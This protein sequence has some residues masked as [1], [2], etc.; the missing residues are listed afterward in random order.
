MVH[1]TGIRFGR[2]TA[3][4]DCRA[5]TVT[6]LRLY[7]RTYEVDLIDRRRNTAT[8]MFREIPGV[9][10]QEIAVVFFSRENPYDYE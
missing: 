7:G 9:D 8:K 10:P 6:F 1:T 3:Y 4:D 2:F 5:Q